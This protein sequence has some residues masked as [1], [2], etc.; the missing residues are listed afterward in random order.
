M[1]GGSIHSFSLKG[2]MLPVA[3]PRFSCPFSL[4][5]SKEDWV[6]N[7]AS[8]VSHEGTCL[9]RDPGRVVQRG[10]GLYLQ[11]QVCRSDPGTWGRPRATCPEIEP[12][13]QLSAAST[14]VWLLDNIFIFTSGSVVTTNMGFQR[15][16]YRK[17][18]TGYCL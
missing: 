8:F 4:S 12:L 10:I 5:R 15:K 17:Q 9:S 2:V 1:L 14:R 11:F 3:I 7:L 18:S 16:R 13:Q 6:S